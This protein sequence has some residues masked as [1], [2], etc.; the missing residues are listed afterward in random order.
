MDANLFSNP[1]SVASF[2]PWQSTPW[3][4]ARNLSTDPF[5]SGFAPSQEN[6]LPSAFS[7]Q[8]DFARASNEFGGSAG[9]LDPDWL[10]EYSVLQTAKAASDRLQDELVA[11]ARNENASDILTAAFSSGAESET[12]DN[13]L[14]N[15]GSGNF[16]DFPSLEIVAAEEL[17]GSVGAYAAENDT[18]YL[19][20]DFLARNADNIEAV[21]SVFLEET[22][23][24]IDAR[25]NLADTPGDE[26]ALFAALVEGKPLSDRALASLR[27]KED[28]SQ[29]QR[30]GEAI[31]IE[32][33]GFNNFESGFFTVG[34]SGQVGVDFLLDGGSFQGELA[35][36]SLEGLE[37]LEPGSEAFILE[38]ATR[39]L[40]NSELGHVVV[41][42]AS[43]GA[44][45]EID[46][47]WEG[48]FNS[49]PYEGIQTF[50]LT[51]GDTF[52]AMLVPNG[53]VEQVF[54]NPSV[55]GSIRP[56]FSLATANPDDAFHVGQIADFT[57]DGTV[58]VMED[59][60]VD[61]GSDRDYN[62]VIFQLS[63]ATG[64]AIDVD[65]V[66]NPDRDLRD[67]E[68]GQNFLQEIADT[69]SEEDTTPPTL[70]VSLTNASNLTI[71]GTVV[72]E[73]DIAE[74]QA[75]FDG[76]F[77]D[78][79]DLLQD[80]SFTLERARLESLFGSVF[81]E[82]SFTL[83]VRAEDA[84]GNVSE[85]A[86]VGFDVTGNPPDDP[87]RDA[88]AIAVSLSNN[89]G[90]SATDDLTADPTVSGRVTDE[91]EIVRLE[92]GFDGSFT[93]I[94]D[95]M[96][97]NGRF[98]LDR[99]A[100][101]TLLG[102]DLIDGN[103]TLDLRAED[104]EGNVSAIAS[105]SFRLDTMAP[106]ATFGL[107]ASDDPDGDGRTERSLVTIE[108]VTEANA[109]VELLGQTTAAN[110]DGNFSFN[111]VALVP[112]NN[113]LALVVA[114]EAGNES[115]IVQNV[116]RLGAGPQ[117]R[118]PEFVSDPDEEAIAGKS[119]LYEAEAIDPD[120][121]EL[122]Y[123]LVAGPAGAAI[124]PTTGAIAWNPTSENIG[125]YSVVVRVEDGKG[126][127][128]EQA[129]AL[130]AIAQ[131][132]NR[133]PV[134]TSFPVVDA[135]VGEEYIYQ[136]EASDEDGD[137][138]TYRL[139][140]LPEGATA[141][142]DE[143]GLLR[144]VP[145]PEDSGSLELT[146]VV[147][148]GNGGEAR[149]I[150]SLNV[151]D[152]RGNAAPIII[153]SDLTAPVFAA[154]GLVHQVEALDADGDELTYSLLGTPA[155]E[156]IEIDENGFITWATD[157]GDAGEHTFEVEVRDDR[158]GF[159][160]QT[161]T[162]NIAD[163][164]L[165][166]V[167]G[168]V[169]YDGDELP[170]VLP[171]QFGLGRPDS[172]N[173]FTPVPAR[174]YY[175]APTINE[176]LEFVPFGAY[177]R[178]NGLDA[179]RSI[180]HSD[181]T[182]QLLAIST[183][184]DRIHQVGEVYDTHN[185][186]EPIPPRSTTPY[187]GELGEILP[188]GT[189]QPFVSEGIYGNALAIAP[190]NNLG[191]FTPGEIFVPGF[192]NG[193]PTL[194]RLSPTGE[195]LDPAFAVFEDDNIPQSIVFDE[196]GAFGGGMVIFA[197]SPSRFAANTFGFFR[198]DRTEESKGEVT[199]I[200]LN[201][202]APATF[203]N[204]V[205]F[206]SHA[207]TFDIVPN[208]LQR[209]GPLAGKIIFG[210][211]FTGLAQI[212]TL[213][214]N[215]KFELFPLVYTDGSEPNNTN[216]PL[217]RDGISSGFS[218][219]PLAPRLVRPN[220]N[221]ISPIAQFNSFIPNS[222]GTNVLSAD[223]LQP[224]VGEII[225]LNST[226]S[227]SA[228]S[229]I[230]RWDPNLG[231][232]GQLVVVPIEP[233]MDFSGS[234][235]F[236]QSFAVFNKRTFTP[237]GVGNAPEGHPG[238]E[239]QIV[240]ADEDG[241]GERDE[242]EVWTT[243]DEFGLYELNLPVG[244]YE[245]RQETPAGWQVT[246]PETGLYSVA[247]AGNDIH[248]G[249]NF[250]LIE[251]DTPEIG[252]RAPEIVS[253]A[254][255]IAFVDAGLTH[256]VEAIDADG[257]D[258]L[259]RLLDETDGAPS[260]PEG[261]QIDAETG[262]ISWATDAG[263]VGTHTFEVEVRD[264]RGGFD[265][266]TITLE[267]TDPTLG[268]V[269]G[270]VYYDGDE[271]PS[272][273]PPQFGLGR[274]DS[275]NYFIPYPDLGYYEG[276]V[277]GE[278]VEVVPFGPPD[279]DAARAIA[280]SDTTGQL[281]T[282]SANP[283]PSQSGE[284]FAPGGSTFLLEPGN[285]DI[286]A[287]DGTRSQLADASLGIHSNAL[288]VASENN[289]GGFDTGDIFV[290]GPVIQDE[291][292]ML[293]G[294]LQRLD[295]AGNVLDA[296]FALF[297]EGRVPQAIR[298]D[299]TGSFGG[300]L[301]IAAI[302]DV[303]LPVP[304]TSRSPA[305]YRVD[306]EGNVIEIAPPDAMA[307]S[308]NA[309][310]IELFRGL[311]YTF[312]IVPND[313][314]RYG[315]IAGDLI[316][317]S[318]F[319]PTLF[320][321]SPSGVIEEIE[322][323]GDD[324]VPIRDIPAG[325][326]PNG[327]F[328][329]GLF[330]QLVQPNQN[331]IGVSQQTLSFPAGTIV[332]AADYFQPFVGE[333]VSLSD[334]PIYSS[335][336]RW[337]P[338]IG[339][340]VWV[341]IDTRPLS[342]DFG[343][344]TNAY[345]GPQHKR[346]FSPAG[347]GNVAA[348]RPGL[349]GQIVF[350]DEDGDG[351]RDADEVW[352][353][354]DEFGLYELNLPVGDY[355]IRQE[356]PAGW[357]VTEP[358]TGLYSV[359][360]AGNDIHSGN[361]FGLIDNNV[362]E[363]ISSA[364]VSAFVDAG[365]TH[366][367]EAIDAD[368]DDLLFRLLDETDGA[369][370]LPEGLQ[371][372]A[373]T[374]WIS[375]ATDAGDVG[376][377][378]F[379]VEV[380]D[381]RG[382]FD[383]QTITLELTDPTLGQ[384][385]G[386]VYYDGDELPSVL[387]PQFGLGRPDSGN[388]FIPY[389]DLGYYEGPVV[390]EDVE[391][392]PF[393][394]PDAD[395]A[396]VIAYSDTTGQ[397]LTVSTNPNPNQ[398]GE[399]FRTGLSV[400]TLDPGNLDIVASDGSR[401]TLV[402]ASAGIYSNALAVVP[403]N[404]LGDF[405]PGDIFVPGPV[406]DGQGTL[407]RLNSAGEIVD[408]EFARFPGGRIPQGIRIDETGL[409]G[410]GLVVVTSPN[411]R[412]DPS[413]TYLVDGNGEITELVPNP[414]DPTSAG[415]SAS[416]T[417]R[418]LDTSPIAPSFEIVPNDPQRYGPIAGH[419]IFFN[420]F[421]SSHIRAIDSQGA[422]KLVPLFSPDGIPQSEIPFH[423]FSALT[424]V[425]RLSQI[426]RPNQNLIGVAAAVPSQTPAGTIVTAADYFQPFVG[427][428]VSLSQNPENSNV[429]R[430]DPDLGQMV[431]VPINP[432]SLSADLGGIFNFYYGIDFQR[433][434]TPAGVGDI[435]AARPGLEGQI[436]F[437]DAD[438]DGERDENEVW[439]TTDEFGLYELNLPVGDYE[440]QQET[441]AGWQA[442]EPETGFYSVAI[443][444][445]DI[446]SGNN[447][448]LL[449]DPT[450]PPP[451]GENQPPEFD[452]TAPGQAVI[453]RETRFRPNAIDPDGDA[454][455]YEFVFGPQ[456]AVYDEARN[457]FI[458]E[459]TEDQVGDHTVVFAATDN[460]GLRTEEEFTVTVPP[461]R[462]DTY[463]IQSSPENIFRSLTT[464]FQS[465]FYVNA[466]D[467]D[468][469]GLD[470]QLDWQSDTATEPNIFKTVSTGGSD[471]FFF[472]WPGQ[473]LGS[474]DFT[475]TV[476]DNE[477]ASDSRSFT[478]NIDNQLNRPPRIGAAIIGRVTEGGSSQVGTVVALDPDNDQ[479]D[480]SISGLDALSINQAGQVFLTEPL[481]PG[482]YPFTVTV[483]DLRGGTDRRDLELEVDRLFGLENQ[484]PSIVSEA[485]HYASVGSLYRY[486][487]E[488]EDPDG[489]APFVSL[490]SGP[491]G[492]ELIPFTVIGGENTFIDPQ[493]YALQ[494]QPT[495]ADIGTHEVVLQV[496]D[497]F[498]AVGEQRFELN[499]GS[500]N[501]PPI[502][503]SAPITQASTQSAYSYQVR[504]IDPEGSALSYAI[505]S[506]DG[507]LTI[508]ENGL[509]QWQPT[510][511]VPTNA[512]VTVTDNRGNE[513]V[514][515]FQI[516]VSTEPVNLAPTIDSLPVTQ[517]GTGQIYDYQ[518]L[519][520]DPEGRSLSFELLPE[521]P[522]FFALDGDRVTAI[523]A[524][525][526]YP[527]GVVVT[528]DGGNRAIQQFDLVVRDNH[529]PVIA[530]TLP[531]SLVLG[532][533]YDAIA[534]ATDL[535]GDR[536]FYSLDNAPDGMEIDNF[537]RIAWTPTATGNYE[538]I[539]LTVTDEF[540]TTDDRTFSVEVTEDAIAPT[541]VV[542]STREVVGNDLGNVADLGDEAIFWVEATDNVGVESVSL[543][544]NGISV[545]L[546]AN[547][548]GRFQTTGLGEFDVEA[549]A[550][551]AAGNV[552]IAP[553]E[554]LTVFGTV[555]GSAPVVDLFDTAFENNVVTNFTPLLG[556]IRDTNLLSY[557]LEVAPLG[558]GEFVEI[559]GETATNG[560]LANIEAGEVG[561][562][563]P[564]LLQNDSYR[565]RLTATDA[566]GLSA[567]DEIV[568]HAAG[569]LKLG[570][571][572]LSF[573]DLT[574][575]V[576]GIPINVTRTYDSLN[577]PYEDDFGFGWRLEF[578][579]TDL[580]TSVTE[581]AVL[582]GVE[583][584][585]P[586]AAFEEGTRVYLTLPGG[587]REG[588]T[589]EPE[590]LPFSQFL[591]T[592][593]FDGSLYRPRFVSD[594]GVTAEL[595]ADESLRL[596]RSEDGRFFSLDSR[597]YD[598]LHFGG[599][600]TLTT[601]EGIEYRIDAATG[602]LDTIRDRNDNVLT[603]TDDGIFSDT[604]I[605]VTFERDEFDRI[606]KVIDPENNEIVYTYADEVRFDP[607]T[608]ERIAT[609]GDLIAVEDREDNVTRLLYHEERDHYLDEIIDPRGNSGVRT[610]YTE[611][612]RLE[613]V[614]DAGDAAVVLSYR[615]ED[616]LFESFDAYGNKT[617]SIYN[618][619]GNITQELVFEG[620]DTFRWSIDYEYGDPRNP[621]L[622]TKT[623]QTYF[624]EG[625]QRQIVRETRYDEN[626]NPTIQTDALGYS[627]INTW[628]DR[629]EL[630]SSTDPEG[631]TNRFE[632]DENGNI[633]WEQNAEGNVT[634]YTY[635]E[636]GQ[637]TS[638]TLDKLVDEV[639]IIEYTPSGY[640]S[641]VINP[642]GQRVEFSPD[643]NGRIEQVRTSIDIAGEQRELIG[644]FV[645]DKNDRV[646]LIEDATGNRTQRVFDPNG[647]LTATFNPDRE[648][649]TKERREYNEKNELTR[650]IYPDGDNNPDNNYLSFAYSYD[651]GGLQNGIF[652][653]NGDPITELKYDTVTGQP[654]EAIYPDE[655]DDPDDNPR[656]ITELDAIGR[657]KQVNRFGE[658]TELELDD[659]N[660]PITISG[661]GGT[662]T[663]EYDKVGREI[664]RVTTVGNEEFRVE[665]ILDNLGRTVEE[666]FPDNTPNDLTDNPRITTIFD[667]VRNAIE[668]TDIHGV[669][670][671]SAFDPLGQLQA[672]TQGQVADST[673][674]SQGVSY[675]R[676]LLGGI[677]RRNANGHPTQ[678][679]VNEHQQRTRVE[680]PLGQEASFAYND[681]NQLESETDFAGNRVEYQYDEQE[682]L[683]FKQVVR[684]GSTDNLFEFVYQDDG[685][686]QAIVQEGRGQTTF[687]YF[688]NGLLKT[689]TQPD[690]ATIEYTYTSDL[691]RVESVTTLAGT[692]TYDY[693]DLD[694]LHQVT[695]AKA[696]QA[697]EVTTYVYVGDTELV[698][699]VQLANGIVE[700]WD[701]SEQNVTVTHRDGAVELA[702]YNYAYRTNGL[703]DRVEESL[704]NGTRTRIIEYDYNDFNWLEREIITDSSE[705]DRIIEYDYDRVGSIQERRET[706]DG[707]TT[708]T[709]YTY[710]ANDRLETRTVS[711]DGGPDEETTYT[712]DDN[713]QLDIVDVLG[714][715]ELVD[716][717]WD[718]EGNLIGVRQ[719]DATGDTQVIS[720]EYDIYGNRVSSTIDGQETRFL[721]DRLRNFAEVIAEYQVNGNEIE[722][723]AEYV[724]GGDTDVI[725]QNRS[726]TSQFYLADG[727][728]DVRQLRT[729]EGNLVGGD[730]YIFDSYGRPLQTPSGVDNPYLY[731][732]E[733]Y[734]S[735]T[736]LQYLRARYYNPELG[737]FL[738]RDPFDGFQGDPL[739]QNPYQYA[740]NDPL[741]YIDPSGAIST[742]DALVTLSV[743][744]ALTTFAVSSGVTIGD[745]SSF[746]DSLLL[747]TGLDTVG[748]TTFDFGIGGGASTE[749]PLD[750]GIGGQFVVQRGFSNEEEN[751]EEVLL[752][753]SDVVFEVSLV[754]SIAMP[755]FDVVVSVGST[756]FNVRTEPL[757]ASREIN[758]EPSVALAET[759]A[760]L[761]TSIDF[762]FGVG[763]DFGAVGALVS[764]GAGV[765]HQGSDAAG[766]QSGVEGS[767]AFSSRGVGLETSISLAFTTGFR[768]VIPYG[769]S[770]PRARQRPE[771]VY[772]AADGL[773][774]LAFGLPFSIL[775]V[776]SFPGGTILESALSLTGFYYGN[777][778]CGAPETL[779]N[780]GLD[781]IR[782]RST[783]ALGLL[784]RTASAISNQP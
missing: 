575:P 128:A 126:G 169:Y 408:P 620:E 175:D 602:D 542:R 558:G 765:S 371:I 497:S 718:V 768:N 753:G 580:R 717:D 372:D 249:N 281:L 419:L 147:E 691:Q 777:A 31:E 209:Y 508:D 445:N 274:P 559:A 88:P 119:Y 699:E 212:G 673:L 127:V 507:N 363:I 74:L 549:Q 703:F 528:D 87:D 160:R 674:P 401:S 57:G 581:D 399:H 423:D 210:D 151:R 118:A 252:N 756:D 576:G 241:D 612:G 707:S 441:P 155:G 715:P 535:D 338:E 47:P 354:T 315:P 720:Y 67:T 444:G 266:Q 33:S 324:G 116:E 767:L 24:A 164:T 224:F 110:A 39:A 455:S 766:V 426:V 211:G 192:Q 471:T 11:F 183:N 784:V 154:A 475:I 470:V 413:A 448:G 565:V 734:D 272:V 406:V 665:R 256:L 613:R 592:Q 432:Q 86:T 84:F 73:S 376:T 78:I 516:D 502:I 638:S 307:N 723:L 330:P 52:A 335:V 130:G 148:D 68:S 225:S 457:I 464:P 713:G 652:D 629:G 500:F 628:N 314:Q 400:F 107:S 690:G 472:E 200:S 409:F 568:V 742:Q 598:P 28:R 276:P 654:T 387:P 93:S 520:T 261:L 23:H 610:E 350:A 405:N 98:T 166:Q 770:H 729:A 600:Y 353:T 81:P 501:L 383:R 91:S 298:F 180:A 449:G 642:L 537:G 50:T 561:V 96:G 191:G 267:L 754:D 167:T 100:L 326:R 75:G 359:A 322:L 661:N 543:S 491:E 347:I 89:T 554:T 498:G 574:I 355:E 334:N 468:G 381:D 566:G 594:S 593:E 533:T 35:F 476:T 216:D 196:T 301:V 318:T 62:D 649:E 63:G 144:W 538:N 738:S 370:S 745:V 1:F 407:Q 283:D 263:D 634:T 485:P 220:Q 285:L 117:N 64:T 518:V 291:N 312:E 431:L 43:E 755:S 437:A 58:F 458:W 215:G 320:A 442:I 143:N 418:I 333:L 513:T 643:V 65:E 18:V 425:P 672:V 3:D 360:I 495:E 655:T 386:Q 414:E 422:E 26:G 463:I 711:V 106:E 403:Q 71:S 622:E 540:G 134:V 259:F 415:D 687:D 358:E 260:L 161:L 454:V 611:D 570:N 771:G 279:A 443:A 484:A 509:V 232:N 270:Q 46:V 694:R 385:T 433:I 113:A 305:L 27:E 245:I 230:V 477:G 140:N 374:G 530:S 486:E 317:G 521:T 761:S 331:L 41:R 404:I 708:L 635:N 633:I 680:L 776:L 168:Q 138:L 739:S 732:S 647:N 659:E 586:E 61:T 380:R 139:E 394:P 769:Q 288:A 646:T 779:I 608:N 722:F 204:Y 253:S 696:G 240:F 4:W 398:S 178:D 70:N 12:I 701:Y 257:D 424:S 342:A 416:F 104:A 51:P 522:S 273:L 632:Y 60:R 344:T 124:E 341:P 146:V 181:T 217:T 389:P 231:E 194:Q 428:I 125:N 560:V 42:D 246:E 352:T 349:E 692:V 13:L 435:P 752:W 648:E 79:S 714:S 16:S 430:W 300:G 469:D 743:I 82:G 526:T 22:G 286:V 451:T 710:D 705:G 236:N 103:Y 439:T 503:E 222:A 721:V 678:F 453:G 99:A 712:Y 377:H 582:A 616:S 55:E 101:E 2:A 313:P 481:E 493:R 505:E 19:S 234:S 671:T 599:V 205:N 605:N 171:P 555:D 66:I 208:D 278:D 571:F 163:A 242:N 45:F 686:V 111:N 137:P 214:P 467:P 238:L 669:S 531:T 487:I 201:P 527:V 689:E 248:S 122:T 188:D 207:L 668:T 243:T 120:G 112:G 551:D 587:E 684:E 227:S 666:I 373:E 534:I 202:E 388:Y 603:F 226:F 17:N 327:V 623:T 329:T 251:D 235:A 25:L 511:A 764:C 645:Y 176:D 617:T 289:L 525:G 479:L 421:D 85:I 296:E 328:P 563:D 618:E 294:T 420:V 782:Q 384:V 512:I 185:V 446:H 348:G 282:V 287:S 157:A 77:V 135:R 675:E 524:A 480:Y 361:N 783:P 567:S 615:P 730:S 670:T 733:Q 490:V 736:G 54:N 390:G 750:F 627:V 591:V 268:Q 579:D 748:V 607:E 336:L 461:A 255:A 596:L 545:P 683:Q 396:R 92:A 606:A 482:T 38:A 337:D 30:E 547:G 772:N 536:L 644:N 97:A 20:G 179:V 504:A 657:P 773:I 133:P 247:I 123:S 392:V 105:L 744:A 412:R 762:G 523:P 725:S 129:F 174:G 589:F 456:G 184:P 10:A 382:G 325:E 609:P 132:P 681:L 664:A 499:V 553:L 496:S 585:N 53:R 630:L 187:P 679:E 244:D 250:G 569:D 115:T 719:T 158:G 749:T 262:W 40:S 237:V 199:E 726:G 150:F 641:A 573:T 564:T 532:Q 557:S 290:P 397:L 709:T 651:V 277:V 49:G 72:D 724:H 29:L 162:F 346:I 391:V 693:D 626:G 747:N 141:E 21:A 529:A 541:V 221:L 311:P 172:G 411:G 340:M 218:E 265:R 677:T 514:Q 450:E 378:T 269:T 6:A 109:T 316:F 15:W 190:Q 519:A 429:L 459:P 704:D 292:G 393:G 619:A 506:S 228:N 510:Q 121:D 556:T 488:T 156:E 662:I 702:Q 676:D 737:R 332:T 667:D 741:T 656:I 223:Y 660:K 562:F 546:D 152:A 631:G 5:A 351:E 321:V 474:H 379:E 365:L 698:D 483:D 343:G 297:D 781:F 706:F 595:T 114:D 310:A 780:N 492:A 625:E 550:T 650:L 478:L 466:Y 319:N 94:L 685:R 578:R 658:I 746:E 731:N 293:K 302:I 489:D 203:A 36:F 142:I 436:V 758:N 427:E 614:I 369:P 186:G 763:L 462:I 299:E 544:V 637:V 604:G 728:N 597:P 102:D 131:P 695:Y 304:I 601:Q 44:K 80:G 639:S 494:W 56:L 165:G 438:G 34:A 198:V 624:D 32:Q 417:V 759:L 14:T 356:T 7:P 760:G 309:S 636:R 367:V 640:L 145:R 258:L 584:P 345:Y 778:I 177:D 153:S 59:L 577:A 362:P 90:S 402:E 552:G 233:V 751:S 473:E 303:N 716:Y 219:T 193:Q 239:G 271:L 295:S 774:N 182:G 539:T 364:E 515:S 197:S 149:Q 264:D 452:G 366:L 440:I 621:D 757:E 37:A 83:E 653:I 590:R 740:N 306:R 368:G 682:R 688:E 254:E 76:N 275:G 8:Q 663:T 323:Y 465:H 572:Q 206:N 700:D 727:F 195:V 229:T 517:V 447:F 434:F 108:G 48:N 159:D 735:E 775:G 460:N 583:L 339:Q 213:D 284:V 410:G 375:W 280:Y 9:L 357:Q 588:F 95:R 170:S 189:F 548:V 136:V 69:P 395:A 308:S 173:N 697:D